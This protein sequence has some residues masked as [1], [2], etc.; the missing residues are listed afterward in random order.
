MHKP[1]SVSLKEEHQK[2]KDKPTQGMQKQCCFHQ[3]MSKC[4]LP[5]WLLSNKTGGEGCKKLLKHGLAT[6]PK[7]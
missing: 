3:I 7:R 6:K 2:I 4:G 5:T 1:P